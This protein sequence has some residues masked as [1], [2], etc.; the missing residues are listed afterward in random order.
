MAFLHLKAN[1]SKVA[2]ELFYLNPNVEVYMSD[3]FIDYIEVYE[4]TDIEETN[5]F[6]S[7]GWKLLNS[8]DRKTV[9][10]DGSSTTTFVFLLGKP[11]PYT[12]S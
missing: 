1:G 2:A 9:F 7:G 3:N 8:T 4:S 6:L 11:N 10:A 12:N 5:T